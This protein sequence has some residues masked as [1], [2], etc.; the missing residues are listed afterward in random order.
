MT[1]VQD[2]TKIVL[3]NNNNSLGKSGKFVQENQ[4]SLLFIVAAVIVMIALVYI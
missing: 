3:D 4:K 2:N 1:K